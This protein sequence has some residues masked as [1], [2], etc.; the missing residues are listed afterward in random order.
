MM[1]SAVLRGKH[2]NKH[3]KLQNEAIKGLKLNEKS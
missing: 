3:Q 2:S 1:L